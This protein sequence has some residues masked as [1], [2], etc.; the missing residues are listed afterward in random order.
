MEHVMKIGNLIER[1]MDHLMEN[2]TENF[3]EHSTEPL[4]ELIDNICNNG[5]T[6]IIDNSRNSKS[7]HPSLYIIIYKYICKIKRTNYIQKYINRI[8]N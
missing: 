2:F 8:K 5:I 6:E 3:M 4:I 1:F 7:T